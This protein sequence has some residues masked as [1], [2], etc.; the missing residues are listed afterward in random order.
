MADTA[1]NRVNVLYNRVSVLI[2]SIFNSA[3]SI[4]ALVSRLSILLTINKTKKSPRP[5]LFV[6][7]IETSTRATE[8]STRAR[9]YQSL[10]YDTVSET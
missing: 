7:S 8:L 1:T 2:R 10:Q 6:E 3:L 4:S 9:P 5:I